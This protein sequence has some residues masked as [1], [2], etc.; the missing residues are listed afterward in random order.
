MY[1]NNLYNLMNQVVQEH[2]SL[3]R[4]KNE[5]LKDAGD[6]DECKGYWEKLAK[7]KEAQVKDLTELVK[8]H[9]MS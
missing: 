6:N 8:K 7:D 9:L 2:K 5:Y 3:W 4:I 1:D